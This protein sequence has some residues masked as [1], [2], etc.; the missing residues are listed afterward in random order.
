LQ[1]QLKKLQAETDEQILSRHEIE[2]DNPDHENFDPLEMDRYSTMQQLSRSLVESVGDLN[3][4]QDMLGGLN[5]DSELL[6]LQQGRVNTELQDRLMQARVV[7]FA[8][9]MA[10]RMRRITRQTCQQLGK[11]ADLKIEGANE[12]MDR[13]VLDRM[14]APLEHMLRNSIAHGIEPPEVR[15]QNGKPESGTITISVRREGG[16]IVIKVADDGAGL[17]TTSIRKKA[18]SKGL[19][20]ENASMTDDEIMQLVLTPGFSTAE[21]VSQISGRGVGMDVVNNEI[22][23]LNGT[24]HIE[25]E[26][27][28]G[29]TMTIRLPFTLSISQALLV[30]VGMDLYAIPLTS[31]EGVSRIEKEEAEQLMQDEEKQ[32][33]Y[34]GDDYQISSLGKLLGRQSG[35]GAETEEGRPAV[36]LVRA[37]GH[38]VGF[39]IDELLGHHEIVVKSLGP[40]VSSVS[41]MAG[42]TILGD[43]RVALI[44]DV[45]ALVRMVGAEHGLSETQQVQVMETPKSVKI[46]VMVVDDSITVRRVTTRLLERH[47]MEVITAK[48][49]VDAVAKLEETVPDVMLLDVE[50]PRMD[51]YELATQ[52]RNDDRYRNVP[53]VMITSR[54][55]AKHRE[56]AESIGVDRYL[57]KPYQ[58]G[59]LVENINQVLAERRDH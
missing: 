30:R 15:R 9:T 6:L 54:T 3:S 43:G 49:G 41:G 22:R 14:V 26:Y 39:Y 16:E 44:L 19:I 56:R 34:G 40:Q 37:G 25:S 38:R 58:E 18:E 1:E 28:K 35:L 10:S 29:A 45:P 31:I 46:R 42:G 17:N 33:H 53:I 32:F 57:G 24:L 12:E 11:Q 52:M 48:D 2:I 50:M 51:G 23:Q 21:S 13:H 55:G 5:R 36:I 59:D 27:G 47:E 8:A 4:L 20:I 7:P